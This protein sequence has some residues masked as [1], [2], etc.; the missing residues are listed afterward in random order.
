MILNVGVIE[1]IH[2]IVLFW[3]VAMMASLKS[4]DQC[5]QVVPYR[6]DHGN[7]ILPM[8]HQE[9]RSFNFSGKEW[10]IKQQWEEIGVAAVVWESVS[11]VTTVQSLDSNIIFH[12]LLFSPAR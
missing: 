12:R 7:T 4:Q 8:F 1:F 11:P 3:S 10:I 9:N 5:Y 6:A 2:L